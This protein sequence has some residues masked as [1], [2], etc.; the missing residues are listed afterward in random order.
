VGILERDGLIYKICSTCLSLLTPM[1][2]P[3]RSVSRGRD[4]YQSSG[5]GGAGNIR[6]ASASRDARQVDASDELFLSRGREPVPSKMNGRNFSTGRGGAGNIRSPS[7]DVTVL[8]PSQTLTEESE[9]E[10]IRNHAVAIQEV[11]QYT[12]RGGL[13][14][15]RVNRSRSRGPATPNSANPTPPP[16]STGRGGAGN[17]FV[18]DAHVP[19]LKEEEERM[20]RFHSADGVRSTGRGGAANL[21]TIAEPPIEYTPHSKTEYESTG[22]GGAGNIVRDRSASSAR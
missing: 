14:N 2:T 19:E 21:T 18:G 4:V 13:G 1:S 3:D 8:S 11:P 17:M 22:R 5:R 20:N 15:I 12:G 9:A 7:R 10:I 16:R 6:Q